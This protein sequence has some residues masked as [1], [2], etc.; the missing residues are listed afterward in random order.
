MLRL[1]VANATCQTL[2]E[3]ALQIPR[4]G[5]PSRGL[6]VS[7]GGRGVYRTNA[8]GAMLVLTQND[9]V[10]MFVLHAMRAMSTD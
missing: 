6:T 5:V 7:A 3:G 4:L 8:R 10:R 2:L 1:A 9:L